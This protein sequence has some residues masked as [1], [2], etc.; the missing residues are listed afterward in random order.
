MIIKPA[1]KS[2]NLEKLTND[3]FENVFKYFVEKDEDLVPE[4]CVLNI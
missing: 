1:L 3:D 2:P 4:F